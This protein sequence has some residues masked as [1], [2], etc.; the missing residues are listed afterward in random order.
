MFKRLAIKPNNYHD[1]IVLMRLARTVRNI[2]RVVEAQVGMATELNKDAVREMGFASQELETATPNDLIVALVAETEDAVGNAEKVVAESLEGPARQHEPGVQ[3]ARI[4]AT[5]SEAAA[6]GGAGIAAISVPGEYAAREAREALANG[7]HVFLFSDNVSVQDEVALK[8]SGK[9]KG[10][11]VM[12]PDCGTAVIGGLG[13]GFA[14]K[15]RRGKIGIVAAA[16]TGLQQVMA[17]IDGLGEGISEAI[18]TGGRDLSKEVGGIATFMGLTFLESDPNTRVKVLISKPP[19]PDVR[20]SLIRM[21][22]EG[23]KPAVVCFMGEEIEEARRK[24]SGKVLFAGDLEKAALLAYQLVTGESKESLYSDDELDKMACRVARTVDGGG[25]FR[26]LYSGGTLCHETLTILR[27]MGIDVY[28]NIAQDRRFL[29]E[30][31]EESCANTCIDMGE[32]YFTRGKP[33]PMLDP[34]MRVPRYLAEAGSKDVGILLFDV[35]LGYGCHRDPAGV[36]ADA[37]REARRIRKD[38][39][40][41]LAQ[42]AVVVGTAGDPQGLEKQAA[43]LREAGAEVLFSNRAAGDLAARIIKAQGGTRPCLR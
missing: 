39:G 41:G 20:D 15:A 24:R 31:A 13:L 28:S 27:R 35:V 6:T 7:L 36:M 12:G 34:G 37:V 33:H 11:F 9:E 19:H 8:K 32:D 26:G 43:V 29:I 42:I 18:G 25:Y 14:N 4:Y 5:L 22:D 23:T 21:L 30:D 3:E 2:D 38:M 17:I 40:Q 16:G 1:S 10:L